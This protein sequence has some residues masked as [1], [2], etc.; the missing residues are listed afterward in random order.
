[1][2][3]SD[4]RELYNDGNAFKVTCRDHRGVIVTLIADNY[5]GYC[6]KEVKSQLSYAANLM[7]MCE[8]EHAGGALTFPSFDLGEDIEQSAYETRIN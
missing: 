2:C 8:E 3:W 4:E 6:K 1:M 7:G 5:F